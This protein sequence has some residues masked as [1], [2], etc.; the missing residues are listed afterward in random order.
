MR[1][2]RN[3]S[4]QGRFL[5]ETLFLEFIF[6]PNH[7]HG[8]SSLKLIL[9]SNDIRGR[10]GLPFSPARLFFF[11]RGPFTSLLADPALLRSIAGDST[12]PSLHGL[13]YLRY[14]RKTLDL[15]YYHY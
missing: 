10:Y 7:D 6:R 11:S 12:S 1:T 13:G 9:L 2:H 5:P 8:L 14:Y 15:R 3:S 4:I